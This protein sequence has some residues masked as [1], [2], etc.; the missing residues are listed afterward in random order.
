MLGPWHTQMQLAATLQEKFQH[1]VAHNAA[2]HFSAGLALTKPGLPIKELAD[3]GE[4]ALNAAKA[5]KEG[6]E[7]VK[8]AICCFEQ[9]VSW[10]TYKELLATRQRLSE[11]SQEFKLS[12]AY[13]YALLDYCQMAQQAKDGNTEAAIWRSRLF[14][15]TERMI[16]DRYKTENTHRAKEIRSRLFEEIISKGIQAHHANWLISLQTHLY[17]HRKIG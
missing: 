2:I 14:Y 17:L 1:Y 9:T 11:L 15:K 16:I 6:G 4:Q 7:N 12:T 3:L 13:L 5:R 8:N 10:D